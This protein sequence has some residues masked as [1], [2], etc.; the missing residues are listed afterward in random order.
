MNLTVDL[1]EPDASDD[2]RT[3]SHTTG[4]S[5]AGPSPV[6][7]PPPYRKPEIHVMGGQ[8][9]LTEMSSLDLISLRSSVVPHLYT[10]MEPFMS[11]DQLLDLVETKRNTIWDRIVNSFKGADKKP[12]SKG[13][14]G[15]ALQEL[16][17]YHGIQS[18]LNPGPGT[19]LIPR[20]VDATIRLMRSQGEFD[21]L[22]WDRSIS[23]ADKFLL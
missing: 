4:A 9:F 22:V 20:F 11:M 15:V 13:T 12:K 10:Y 19:V 17:N 5:S 1:A 21:F 16:D 18:D 2:E 6:V 7:L 8:R 23:F 3:Y 14:F